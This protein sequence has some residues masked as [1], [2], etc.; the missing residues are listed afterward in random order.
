MMTIDEKALV[1][2]RKQVFMAQIKQMSKR[3]K[4]GLGLKYAS[5]EELEE[6]ALCEIDKLVAG[7]KNLRRELTERRTRRS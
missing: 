5:G 7:L 6:E 1:F 3:I 4:E 2:E